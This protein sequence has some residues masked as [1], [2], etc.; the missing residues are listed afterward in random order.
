MKEHVVA[1]EEYLR[2][3]NLKLTVPRQIILDAIFS[4][5]NHFDAETLCYSL[6]KKHKLV[7]RATVYRTIK[8]LV[9]AGMVQPSMRYSDK[10]HYEHIFGHSKHIHMLCTRCQ[11][12]EEIDTSMIENEIQALANLKNF[13]I[14]DITITLKGVCAKCH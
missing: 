2:K 5:H 1:F 14:D 10:E 6:I 3:Q 4:T 12:I 13:V 8:L 9:D 7:S 11:S